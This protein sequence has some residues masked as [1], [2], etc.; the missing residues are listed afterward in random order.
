MRE[1]W[2]HL[3]SAFEPERPQNKQSSLAQGMWPSLVKPPP[4]RTNNDRE[5]LLRH[6]RELNSRIDARM[7]RERRR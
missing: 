2:P 1:I 7:E 4:Q 5:S 6:L 3:R